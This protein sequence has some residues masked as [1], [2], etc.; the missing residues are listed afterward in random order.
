[1][2]RGAEGVMSHPLIPWVVSVCLLVC[3]FLLAYGG[4]GIAQNLFAGN[5]E[6][7]EWF[8]TERPLD[9]EATTFFTCLAII[10]IGG[11]GTLYYFGDSIKQLEGSD[12]M[13]KNWQLLTCVA[14]VLS[15][16]AS[17]V[18][19]TLLGKEGPITLEEMVKPHTMLRMNPWGVD[20][21]GILTS[22]QVIYLIFQ[23]LPSERENSLVAEAAPWFMASLLF[24]TL[25]CYTFCS[26]AKEALWVSTICMGLVPYCLNG[27]HKAITGNPKAYKSWGTFFFAQT[28][29]AVHYAWATCSALNSANKMLV[30]IEYPVFYQVAWGFFGVYF[31]YQQ[32][33]SLMPER[34]DLVVGLTFAVCILAI[35]QGTED[36]Y[37][38]KSSR[39]G[40]LRELFPSR[41]D[42]ALQ[43]QWVTAVF[44]GASIIISAIGMARDMVMMMAQGGGF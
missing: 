9:N 5:S 44:L 31:A 23:A 8:M 38:D 39:M 40:C 7:R 32:G 41:D 12:S 37:E 34:K 27:A 15:N 25:W 36:C 4:R 33:N 22:C 43:A 6:T 2:T 10:A 20:V 19:V 21:E 17:A 42:T 13:F 16:V 11:V 24:R 3:T 35:A 29:L 1:M 26:W 18:P 14:Y 30:R 28:P